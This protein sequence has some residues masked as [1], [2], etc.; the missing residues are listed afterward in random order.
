M[1]ACPP[2]REG[3][4]T[5]SGL[6]RAERLLRKIEAMPDEA[7]KIKAVDD[8]LREASPAVLDVGRLARALLAEGVVPMPTY[9]PDWSDKGISA[10]VEAAETQARIT[11]R[12]ILGR[13]SSGRSGLHSPASPDLPSQASDSEG[14][15]PSEGSGD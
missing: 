15:S 9:R 2:Y 12:A 5:V 6:S 4:P 1:A 10:A 11:A 13:L 8:A 3:G 14:L 7:Y